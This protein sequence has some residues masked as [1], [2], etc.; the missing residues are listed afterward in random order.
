MTIGLAFLA[1]EIVSLLAFGKNL[2]K[3]EGS[4]FDRHND[5]VEL[6]PDMLSI[7]LGIVEACL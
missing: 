3:P 4:G 6:L 5:L 1:P 2:G 7:F